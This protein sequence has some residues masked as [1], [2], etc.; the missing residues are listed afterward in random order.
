MKLKEKDYL[1]A[2][3]EIITFNSPDIVTASGNGDWWLGNDG[4]VDAG[5]WT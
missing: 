3:V 2:D 1:P 5:G 4:N